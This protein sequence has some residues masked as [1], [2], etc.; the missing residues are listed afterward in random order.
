[1]DRGPQGQNNAYC[2]EVVPVI[3]V[4]NL[5]QQQTKVN[6]IAWCRAPGAERSRLIMWHTHHVI[7]VESPRKFSPS[8]R[9]TMCHGAHNSWISN[10]RLT[11]NKHI[12]VYW[13]GDKPQLIFITLNLFSQMFVILKGGVMFEKFLVDIR[14]I[15]FSLLKYM[16]L[17]SSDFR[18]YITIYWLLLS[19]TGQEDI[20]FSE[21]WCY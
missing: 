3:V 8:A 11:I 20:I 10:F 17:H 9:V 16:W 2:R 5:L 7:R 12:Y 4:L 14:K 15:V 19:V 6:R 18:I 1:M 21:Q 13:E